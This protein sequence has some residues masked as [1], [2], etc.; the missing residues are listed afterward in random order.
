[1]TNSNVKAVVPF[2]LVLLL[3]SGAGISADAGK[4]QTSDMTVIT[5][6]HAQ[7]TQQSDQAGGKDETRQPEQPTTLYQVMGVVLF[8][9]LGLA[10]FIFRLDRRVTKLEYQVKNNK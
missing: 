3:I 6:L 7:E 1:M 8:I 2:I 10:L 5:D 9:W 4:H